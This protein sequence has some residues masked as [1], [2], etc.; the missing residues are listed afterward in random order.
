M[1]VNHFSESHVTVLFFVVLL[2][3]Q[4]RNEIKRMQQ[5]FDSDLIE[6][7]VERFEEFLD[8]RSYV[9]SI[10]GIFFGTA[11]E[12]ADLLTCVNPPAWNDN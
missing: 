7:F 6:G 10:H 1:T 2:L 3:L 12:V 4:R 8:A 11:K 9:M 5:K